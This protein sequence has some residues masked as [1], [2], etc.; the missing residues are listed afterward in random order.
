MKTLTTLI[1]ILT[2]SQF[3]AAALNSTTEAQGPSVVCETCTANQAHM[4]LKELAEVLS[5]IETDKTPDNIHSMQIDVR[6][7]ENS[8]ANAVG[9]IFDP[10]TRAAGTGFIAEKECLVLTAKHTAC[11]NISDG[12]CLNQNHKLI[13][14]VGKKKN[15]MTDKFDYET[16]GTVVGFG[17]YQSSG[18]SGDWALI[19]IKKQNNK[20]IGELIKPLK[21][22]LMPEE[23]YK[24][25][26]IKMYG[27][28]MNKGL[29]KLYAD[30]DC[31]A[32]STRRGQTTYSCNGSKG[33]S[34]GP[35]IAHDDDGAPWVVGLVSGAA[36]WSSNDNKEDGFMFMQSF[37]PEYSVK[38]RKTD[39]QE[40]QELIN[41]T[42]CD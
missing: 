41:E 33:Y 7:K 35:V 30:N 2:L 38:N 17:H 19:K 6:K 29:S 15:S 1:T 24:D 20:N 18:D 40:I 25:L 34:G 11:A 27:Y 16:S 9:R 23:E 39:G 36:K 14:E 13:F 26:P 37:E 8:H 28:P 42:T 32:L 4:T 5:K 21:I 22:Y 31:K 12:K 10:N 3:S